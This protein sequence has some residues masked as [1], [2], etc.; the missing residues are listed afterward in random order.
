MQTKLEK[1]RELIVEKQGANILKTLLDE[2]NGN[3]VLRFFCDE[4]RII[5]KVSER[6]NS[7]IDELMQEIKHT[8]NTYKDAR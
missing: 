4:E 7:E 6:F 8:L 2:A 1:I 3:S 5:D